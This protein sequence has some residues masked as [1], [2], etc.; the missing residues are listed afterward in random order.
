MESSTLVPAPRLDIETFSKVRP[1]LPDKPVRLVNRREKRINTFFCDA[2]KEI[3]ENP[4]EAG[5]GELDGRFRIDFKELDLE[6]TFSLVSP[7]IGNEEID[8]IEFERVGDRL[9][10]SQ[11]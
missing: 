6:A 7:V 9:A 1:R 5:T 10:D 2:F 8:A 11:N 4:S 3:L